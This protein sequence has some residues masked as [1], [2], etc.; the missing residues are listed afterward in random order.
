MTPHDH[1]EQV[2]AAGLRDEGERTKIVVLDHQGRFHQQI[3]FLR[4]QFLQDGELPFSNVL[5]VE[6]VYERFFSWKFWP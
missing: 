2:L 6:V 5:S 1:F 4:R 3:R